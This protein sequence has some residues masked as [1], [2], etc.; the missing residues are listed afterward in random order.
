MITPGY[1]RTMAAYN[2]ELNRRIYGAAATLT[3]A[4]RR[5]DGGAFFKSIHATLC[6]ILWADMLWLSRF[7]VG[8]PPAVPIAESGSL[9][10]DFD[11][12]RRRRE[13]FDATII[14]W[15]EG[16]QPEDL[17]GDITWYS[18]AVGREMRKPR[19]L[20]IMQLFNHQTHHRGQVH[21]LLTR[22]GAQTGA[23][24]LPFVLPD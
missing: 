13:A 3:D 4:E 11:D 22:A 20:C 2:A 5:A 18:G 16:V 10:E 9:V 1:I 24:D 8:T 21:A 6:H 19:M 17:P 15:G 14:Q 12:L 23:T 7:G